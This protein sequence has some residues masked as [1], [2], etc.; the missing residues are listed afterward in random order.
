MTDICMEYFSHKNIAR[1]AENNTSS[2]E[3]AVAVVARFRPNTVTSSHWQLIPVKSHLCAVTYRQTDR[4][5]EDGSHT[6]RTHARTNT[7]FSSPAHKHS[8]SVPLAF[9]TAVPFGHLV[10][11][12]YMRSVLLCDE[13]R[14]H[15]DRRTD[16][17]S[18]MP[19]LC[20]LQ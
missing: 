16:A 6:A 19:P 18:F 4:Q 11:H 3:Y 17:L 2:S 20:I 5:N 14:G 10:E 12:F 8:P 1:N 7:Q 13:A 15:T 9:R